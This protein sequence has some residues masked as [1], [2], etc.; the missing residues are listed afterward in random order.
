MKKVI[1][2]ESQ[3]DM[4]KKHISES[5]VGNERYSR[6]VKVTVYSSG[7]K[8]NGEDVDWASSPNIELSYLIE[9]EHRSWGIKGISLYSIEGPSEIEFEITPQVDDAD[10]ITVTIPVSW[11]TVVRENFETGEG[12]ITLGNEI[13]VNLMN[14]EN[15][16]VVI[17]Y[18]D[19]TVYTL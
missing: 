19:V 8:F 15:G 12:V 13:E 3:L 16:D 11:D 5:A 7:V 10:D 18:I 2:T 6:E 1:L 9:Q 17:D 14:N 4:V